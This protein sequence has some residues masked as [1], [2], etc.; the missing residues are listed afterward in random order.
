MI[1]NRHRLIPHEE[2]MEVFCG[3]DAD[4]NPGSV[5]RTMVYRARGALAEGGLENAEGLIIAKSG[6]YMW[7]RHIACTTDIEDFEA[8]LEKANRDNIEQEERLGLLTQAAELYKGDFLPNSKSDLW[9]MPLA[10]RYRSMYLGCVH[11][12]LKI[13]DR[14]GRSDE[15]AELCTKALRI[16]PFD[17][18]LIEYNLR[19]LIAQKKNREALEI[20]KK[21]ET[22][23]FDV[24]GVNFSDSLRALYS[25][26][27]HPDIEKAMSL[28]ELLEE[29]CMDADYPGAYYCD[30][31]IFRTLFQIEARSV[32]RSGRTAFIVRFDTVHEP[33]K[34]DGGVM[35]ALSRIIPKCLRMGDLY[36]RYSPNQYII[37]L[38]SLTYE[39]C[40]MLVNRIL[41]EVGSKYSQKVIE[42]SISHVSHLEQ[43]Q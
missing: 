5:M 11:E 15:A 29:W 2:L 4:A 28:G 25:V 42:T 32:P 38:Y 34:R 18:A 8:L 10:R 23:F 33:T 41:S 31:G 13:L 27:S 3:E 9:V 24:L 35:K 39:D 36:T 30:A 37:M 19:A 40:K 20:Y 1:A 6:G 43:E 26:I 21:M 16:D 7:N 22:M 14:L 17:E 12:V